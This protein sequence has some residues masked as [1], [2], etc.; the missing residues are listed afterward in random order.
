MNIAQLE[1][2]LDA[3]KERWNLALKALAANYGTDTWE[4]CSAAHDEVLQHQRA[5]A[6]AKGEQYAAPSDFPIRWDV[7]AP[8]PHVIA[9]DY[10]TFLIFYAREAAPYNDGTPVTLQ[11]PEHDLLAVVEFKHCMSH[12]MGTPN[13]DVHKGHPLFGKGLD[14]Y[15][16]QIVHNSRWLTELETINKVHRYYRESVWQNLTHYIFWFHDG[17]FECIAESYKVELV[18]DTLANLLTKVCANFSTASVPLQTLISQ[19]RPL[20]DT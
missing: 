20:P 5:L 16:A 4:Q 7:G 15:T 6:Q 8:L 11:N 13:E 3:A 14:S 17:T 12:R 18:Q 19:N 1:Q 9:N 10:L 2:Q